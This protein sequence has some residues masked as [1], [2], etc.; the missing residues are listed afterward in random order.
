MLKLKL[1]FGKLLISAMR[2]PFK[3]VPL[4]GSVKNKLEMP[5]SNEQSIDVVSGTFFLFKVSSGETWG[6][7]SDRRDV[8]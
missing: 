3:M 1:Y 4:K 5:T 6:G 2:I 8:R 7:R